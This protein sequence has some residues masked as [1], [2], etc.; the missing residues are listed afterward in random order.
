MQYSREYKKF[1]E[2]IFNCSFI[3]LK[4]QT[5]GHNISIFWMYMDSENYSCT[6]D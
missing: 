1:L 5:S 3:Q 2:S 6:V 4:Q